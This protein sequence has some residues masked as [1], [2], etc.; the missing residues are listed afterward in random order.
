AVACLAV[1]LSYP[2]GLGS[3]SPAVSDAR[4]VVAQ[5]GRLAGSL[6]GEAAYL[7]SFPLW[8]MLL[9][10]FSPQLELAA[11]LLSGLSAV[12]ALYMAYQLCH[13]LSNREGADQQSVFALLALALSPTFFLATFGGGTETP[14]LALLLWALLCVQRA[15][16]AES[17]LVPMAL[18]GLLVGLSLLMRPVSVLMP[19]AVG[20]W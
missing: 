1:L 5:G 3:W 15:L 6:P 12:F 8:T 11:R 17:R 14:H 13:A 20:L 16:G 18:A 2:S 10:R 9:A 4:Q 19:A 7:P